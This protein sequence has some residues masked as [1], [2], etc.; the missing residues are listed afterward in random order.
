MDDRGTEHAGT[1]AANGDTGGCGRGWGH[2][3]VSSVVSD[4][5]VNASLRVHP[6]PLC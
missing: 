4:E 2:S 5:E 3:F 6:S 1:R